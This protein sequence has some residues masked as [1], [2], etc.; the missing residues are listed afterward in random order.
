[1]K[2]FAG[3]VM[4]GPPLP[5]SLV[6]VVMVTV[7]AATAASGERLDPALV[8]LRGLAGN[9]MLGPPLPKSLVLV[10]VMTVVAATAASGERLDPAL[11]VL[12]GATACNLLD[13]PFCYNVFEFCHVPQSMFYCK[14]HILLRNFAS[15]RKTFGPPVVL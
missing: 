2:G 9:V 10:V 13:A 8:V 6:L 3:N 11:V 15:Q 4:L 7:V 1:M 14:V 5:K 12:G